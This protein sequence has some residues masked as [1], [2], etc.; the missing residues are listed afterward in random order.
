MM[1]GLPHPQYPS[2]CADRSSDGARGRRADQVRRNGCCVHVRRQHRRHKGQRQ[3]SDAIKHEQPE[4]RPIMTTDVRHLC[5]QA[6]FVIRGEGG[7][8]SWRRQALFQGRQC[9]CP[10][11]TLGGGV[12]SRR[13][14]PTY[15]LVHGTYPISN[16]TQCIKSWRAHHC[17]LKTCMLL[18]HCRWSCSN[19][20]LG[21]SHH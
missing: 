9:F 20:K 11:L 10:T 12:Q 18:T 3:V 13:Q 2:S 8:G 14:A 4:M 7:G 5:D 16:Y 21:K 6:F 1:L 17:L 19:Q 15:R